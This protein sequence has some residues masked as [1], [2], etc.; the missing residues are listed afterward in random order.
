[1]SGLRTY[2]ATNQLLGFPP[3]TK[4]VPHTCKIVDYF[5]CRFTFGG[6]GANCWVNG[7]QKGARGWGKK[8]GGRGWAKGVG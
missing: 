2:Y 7:L 6:G 3:P 5:N 1:M 4:E 8:G